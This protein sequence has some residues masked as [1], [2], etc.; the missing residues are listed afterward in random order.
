MLKS[1]IVPL[2]A[3]SITSAIGGLDLSMSGKIARR[4]II[5]YFT[6]TISAVVLGICLVTTIR[7][8]Q[9]A[10]IIETHMESIDKASKVLTPDTLMD[11]IRLVHTMMIIYINYPLIQ[12]YLTNLGICLPITLFNRPCF[13]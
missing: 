3:S 8:G 10:K 11:L 2:L 7:P 9:G 5:Y 1:L 6:T 12:C 13:R 4:A